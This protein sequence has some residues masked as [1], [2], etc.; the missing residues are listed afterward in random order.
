MI[1]DMYVLSDYPL[2]A[3][4]L[5]FLESDFRPHSTSDFKVTV[6]A[7]QLLTPDV[8]AHLDARLSNG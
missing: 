8:P 6:G 4:I 2:F 3:A 7:Q 5:L 1:R